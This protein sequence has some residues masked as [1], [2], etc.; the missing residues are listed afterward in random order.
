MLEKQ[1]N[2]I[3]PLKSKR[4]KNIFLV[5]LYILIL[6]WLLFHGVKALTLDM[7]AVLALLQNFSLLIFCFAEGERSKFLMRLLM[8]N[9]SAGI[10][11]A[12]KCCSSPSFQ[13]L[14]TTTKTSKQAAL[15]LSVQGE[16]DTLHD[17]SWTR[18]QQEE[19]EVFAFLWHHCF[20]LGC[21]GPVIASMIAFVFVPP[22]L[23]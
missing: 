2:N 13:P 22:N 14:M 5:I 23:S 6:R 21:S 1:T 3:K 16:M 7:C 4:T 18:G 8:V 19:T 9:P 20:N 11:S 12:A 17:H 15:L 10:L